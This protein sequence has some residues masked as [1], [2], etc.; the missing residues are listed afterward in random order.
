MPASVAMAARAAGRPVFVVALRG[1]ADPATI[2]SFPHAVLRLGAAEEIQAHL[3][4]NDVRDVVL[5]GSVRRPTPL[6]LRPD[7][8]MRR[9]LLRLGRDFFRGDDGLLG[10]IVRVMS[11]EGYRVLGAHEIM[12]DVIGP[13]GQLT[14][15]APDAVALADIQRG[16]AVVRALGAAD[17]GQGCVVQQGLVLAV[18][19]VEGTDAM[20][21]RAGA[22][23][24]E[25]EG[26]VLVKLVKPAQ[27]R[28][29]DLPTIG[30]ATVEAARQAGLR[31]IAYEAEGTMIVDRPAT[32]A[33]AD[34]AGLFLLGLGPTMLA[35]TVQPGDQVQ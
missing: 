21:A 32:I 34:A 31:G 15:A 8:L 6:E 30:P 1:H 9:L 10:S 35:P 13:S 24:R 11:E 29:I 33:A 19:A 16:I 5:V 25:G 22:L 26:G 14:R 4:A 27:D 3:R 17:V 18:E 23:A 2:S 7:A 28:R 12:R 20:L